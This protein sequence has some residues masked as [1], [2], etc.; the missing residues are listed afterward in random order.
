M[1]PVGHDRVQFN[2]I[3]EE[4]ELALSGQ[5]YDRKI[6]AI[7]RYLYSEVHS[8][9]EGTSMYPELVSDIL[10]RKRSILM[11]Y[12]AIEE[13]EKG[14]DIRPAIVL[15]LWELISN[16]VLGVLLN[17]GTVESFSVAIPLFL[18]RTLLKSFSSVR[19]FS[20]F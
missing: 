10:R 8:L 20:G 17:V 19:R 6:E 14:I 18:G 4:E 11:K 7:K 16:I 2:D 9:A 12:E 1:N 15:V 3:L 13:F 5:R